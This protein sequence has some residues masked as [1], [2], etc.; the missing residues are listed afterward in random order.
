MQIENG[1]LLQSQQALQKLSQ[2]DLKGIHALHLKDILGPIQKRLQRLQEVQQDLMEREDMTE[3]E[4]DEE[5]QM[6]LSDSLDVD[7]EPLPQKAVED[8][9][10]S[11]GALMTLDWLIDEDSQ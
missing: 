5:W 7:E 9:E 2:A 4:A 6:V 11:A 10:I 1:T 3:D 8:I